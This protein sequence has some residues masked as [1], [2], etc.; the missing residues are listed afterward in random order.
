M[1][2]VTGDFCTPH[3]AMEFLKALRAVRYVGSSECV[4]RTARC[5]SI[6]NISV[7]P[8]GASEMNTKV[9]VK[10]MNSIRHVGDAIAHEISRQSSCVQ[11]GEAVTLHTRLWDPD[12]KVTLPMRAKFE[13]P[14]IPDPTVPLVELSREWIDKMR[15]RLPEMPA[16]RAARFVAQHGL[17]G[18]EAAYLSSDPDTAGFFD[19]LTAEGIAP[20]MA[21]HGLTTQLLPAMKERRQ[22]LHNSPVTPARFAAL[23]RM[24][25]QDQIN[26]NAARDVLLRL[27]DGDQPRRR[28]LTPADSGRF[29]IPTPSGDDRQGLG[30]GGG[31]R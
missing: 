21:M 26:A 11:A 14:C 10:N 7:R 12:K 15:S 13:G 22:E 5:A 29:P 25:S 3:E 18:E 24:L 2:I 30:R 16:T 27:F 17:S 31:G 8:R 4:W 23:L 19:A 6:A 1:E 28:S 9:E 20:R